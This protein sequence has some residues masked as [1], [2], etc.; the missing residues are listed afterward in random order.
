MKVGF[1]RALWG[2]CSGTAVFEQLKQQ[3]LLTAIWH[4]VLM[5]LI[6]AF[7][8]WQGVYPA[9]KQLTDSSVQ[10]FAENCGT[11]VLGADKFEPLR[12][13]NRARVFTIAGPVSVT[14]LPENAETLPENYQQECSTG[15]IWS[16]LKIGAW[17]KHSDRDIDFY[18]EMG[19]KVVK[20]DSDAALLDALRK[21]QAAVNTKLLVKSGKTV[22]FTTEDIKN[23]F[24]IIL[25]LSV[26]SIIFIHIAQIV[27]YILVFAVVSLLM[28]L[29]RKRYFSFKELI[30]LAIYAGFPAM[31]I[32]SAAEA[33]QLPGL[34]FDVIYVLGMTIYL[35]IVMNRIEYNRQK[36]QW[37]QENLQ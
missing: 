32:G 33:L 19:R 1:F 29:G 24:E 15:I 14:Y 11:L 17:V 10:V 18:S 26:G 9:L 4:F 16:G 35:I 2:S 3:K 37:Q 27:F 13:P 28:N 8:M 21:S 5:S 23:W 22:Q 34:N 12:H 30:V 25:K 36:R 6:C 20:V 31:I 7:F